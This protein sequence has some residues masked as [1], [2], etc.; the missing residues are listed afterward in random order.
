MTLTRRK[1]EAPAIDGRLTRRN[2][3]TTQVGGVTFRN[4]SAKKLAAL[5]NRKKKDEE[6]KI[7]KKEK[8][9]V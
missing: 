8:Q 3:T 4:T 5:E 2:Y 9:A 6:N 1:R 7:N